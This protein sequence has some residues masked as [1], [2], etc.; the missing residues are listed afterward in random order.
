[1]T[2]SY[3]YPRPALSVDCV[4][5]GLDDKDILKVLLICR[6]KDPFLN[7]WALPGGFVSPERDE[8]IEDAARRELKEETGVDNIFLEQLYT[9]GSKNRDPRDW[10]AS[11]AYYALI[12]LGE[13]PIQAATDAD[14]AAWFPITDL[15]NPLA[16][17][18][19]K[20]VDTAIARLRNNI[21]YKPI[22]F[23]LLPKKFTLPQLLKLYETVLGQSLDKRNFIRKFNKMNLLVDL[24]ESQKSVAH[25]PA[26]L[27][28]FNKQAY[29]Q[30][31][32]KGFNFEI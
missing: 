11:V 23:E 32:K 24:N 30:L 3:K 15:P 8:S 9:F 31:Q 26:K 2:Y 14:E 27:Y 17:D 19:Q 5:F 4:V 28:Q 7:E 6:N 13:H 21:R 1:M 29:L 22:G 16:F 10:V 20:I 25:R 12:N 18:H